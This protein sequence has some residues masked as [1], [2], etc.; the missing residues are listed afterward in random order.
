MVRGK[1]S[2]RGMKNSQKSVAQAGMELEKSLGAMA[3]R[4]RM[5]SVSSEAQLNLGWRKSALSL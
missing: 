5:V 3:K 4:R 2:K 1:R